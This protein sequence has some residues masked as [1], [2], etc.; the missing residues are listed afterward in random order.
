MEALAVLF[1]FIYMPA[2][3][4][5]S[6]YMLARAS[7]WSQLA[8]KYSCD[9][10]YDGEKKSWQWARFNKIAY[11]SCLGIALTPEGLHIE[12]QPAFLYGFCHPPLCI[13]WSAIKGVR[14]CKY[15]WLRVLECE[16]ND[17]DVKIMIRISWLEEGKSFFADK[18]ILKDADQLIGD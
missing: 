6:L 13:P 2:L 12:I 14:E 8:E 5:G 11:K 10:P 17:T 3:W 7:G 1:M 9:G 15:W 18:L 16:L 4:F